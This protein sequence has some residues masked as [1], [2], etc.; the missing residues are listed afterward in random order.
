M[1]GIVRRLPTCRCRCHGNMEPSYL[2]R[3]QPA[4]QPGRASSTQTCRSDVPW[5]SFGLRRKLLVAEHCSL[6]PKRPPLFSKIG[7]SSL[8]PPPAPCCARL[9]PTVYLSLSALCHHVA[10]H[11]WPSPGYWKTRYLVCST[12]QTKASA[13]NNCG[14]T[15]CSPYSAATPGLFMASSG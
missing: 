10:S 7:P 1:G 12:C 3:A 9:I 2:G 6:R 4:V 8:A 5:R 14:P 13:V 11:P 15:A